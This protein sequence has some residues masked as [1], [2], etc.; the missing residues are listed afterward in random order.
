MTAVT[1]TTQSYCGQNGSANATGQSTVAVLQDFAHQSLLY[2]SSISHCI[3]IHTTQ[4]FA[5][6]FVLLTHYAQRSR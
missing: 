1:L 4:P 6:V 3:I 2:S 5:Q